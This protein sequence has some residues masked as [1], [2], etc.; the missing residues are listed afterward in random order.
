MPKAC[1]TTRVPG[2]IRRSV[3]RKRR[4]S[5]GSRYSVTTVAS[6]KSV[7]K[8]SPSTNRAF[9]ATPYSRARRSETATR[10]GLNSTPTD[11]AARRAAA[12][13]RRPSPEPRS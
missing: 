5:D 10:S 7:S 12:I 8:M 2:F 11:R 13:T 6:E 9:P 3:G 1:E 4:L